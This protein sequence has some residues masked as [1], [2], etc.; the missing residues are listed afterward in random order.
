MILQPT[1]IAL[2]LID[3]EFLKE[4][5][6]AIEKNLSQP[7]FG[8]DELAQALYMSRAGLNLKARALTGESTNKFIQSYR[9][10]RT[11]KL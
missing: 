2:A 8:V 7:V 6:E 10:K 5:K 1:E 11:A 3:Q 4:L 9:L